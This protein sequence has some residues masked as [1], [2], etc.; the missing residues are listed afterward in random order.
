MGLVVNGT[1]TPKRMQNNGPRPLNIAQKAIILHTVGP[2][3]VHG[4]AGLRVR[5]PGGAWSV[6]QR[7]RRACK[8][9]EH[10]LKQPPGPHKYVK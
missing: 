2:G 6:L 9:Q 1:W 4:V 7:L 3:K 8:P 10:S 5:R